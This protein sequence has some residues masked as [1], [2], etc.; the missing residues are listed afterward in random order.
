MK[1][2]GIYFLC[3]RERAER[4]LEVSEAYQADDMAKNIVGYHLWVAR[5]R[6]VL[7]LSYTVNSHLIWR[8]FGVSHTFTPPCRR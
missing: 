2:V 3:H 7:L 5:P 4:F 6:S 8:S 1:P